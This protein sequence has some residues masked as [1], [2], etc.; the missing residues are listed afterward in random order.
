MA[1]VIGIASA[2]ASGSH[3]HSGTAV[4]LDT[5]QI[6]VCDVENPCGEA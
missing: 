5:S 2:W 4:R 1:M 6:A 3:I